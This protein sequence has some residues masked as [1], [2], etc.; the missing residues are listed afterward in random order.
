MA[1]SQCSGGVHEELFAAQGPLVVAVL[2]GI[3]SKEF[4]ENG[5]L[6]GTPGRQKL[7]EYASLSFNPPHYSHAH[8]QKDE[9]EMP[10]KGIVRL[11]KRFDT[12]GEEDIGYAN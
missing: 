12:P 10:E 11:A 9:P 7:A 2:A 5:R 8:W 6:S 1:I 3:L 4:P